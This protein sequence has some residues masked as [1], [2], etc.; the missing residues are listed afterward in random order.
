M[1]PGEYLIGL[2]KQYHWAVQT[3][4]SFLIISLDIDIFTYQMAIKIFP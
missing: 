1:P 2:V 4:D 3:G